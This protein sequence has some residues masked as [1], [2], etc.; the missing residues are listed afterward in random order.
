[1]NEG[2]KR[3]LEQVSQAI[4]ALQ[5]VQG[6]S[7]TPL[8]AALAVMVPMRKLDEYRDV[9]RRKG[10]EIS[11]DDP[12]YQAA[13]EKLKTVSATTAKELATH[14]SNMKL[15]TAAAQA[16][17]AVLKVAIAVRAIVVGA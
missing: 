17:A 2:I 3:L 13:M 1:M 7:S 14:E 10:F 15:V 9:L 11:L 4:T 6:D 5:A 16:A 12:D 8:E